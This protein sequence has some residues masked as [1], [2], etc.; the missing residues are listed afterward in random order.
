MKHAKN[1]DINIFDYDSH[2]PH[3]SSQLLNTC[4]E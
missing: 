1:Y 4:P 2:N 3:P